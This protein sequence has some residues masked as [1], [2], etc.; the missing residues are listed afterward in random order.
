MLPVISGMGRINTLKTELNYLIEVDVYNSFNALH[1]DD[2]MEKRCFL[3][4]SL[5]SGLSYK[6]TGT[7]LKLSEKECSATNGEVCKF[8]FEQ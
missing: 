5:I 8:A 7:S 6:L 3:L 1:I 4:G 2:S